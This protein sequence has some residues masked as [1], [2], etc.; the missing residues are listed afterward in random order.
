MR[1]KL[2]TLNRWVSSHGVSAAQIEVRKGATSNSHEKAEIRRNEKSKRPAD[3]LL[4]RKGPRRLR[5]ELISS[6]SSWTRMQCK[7][8]RHV[9]MVGGPQ[10]GRRSVFQFVADN[11]G[12][13]RADVA[14]EQHKVDALRQVRDRVLQIDGVES[15]VSG[16][17]RVRR[18]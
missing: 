14:S 12:V 15:G 9:R 8:G 16:F 13:K 7:T 1:L 4:G 10:A 6:G 17:A 2:R 3:N 5:S 18:R 11:L